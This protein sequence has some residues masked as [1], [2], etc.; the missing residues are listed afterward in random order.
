METNYGTFNIGVE[1]TQSFHN[2]RIAECLFGPAVA[3]NQS[4]SS[5]FFNNCNSSCNSDCDNS[6][7]VNVVGSQAPTPA[8]GTSD[9]IADAFLLPRDFSSNIRFSPQISNVNVPM[10]VYIGF[11][12]WIQGLYFR[13]YAPIT[14]TRWKLEANETIVNQGTAGY[15]AGEISPVVVPASSLY[16]SFLAYTSGGSITLPTSTPNVI[17]DPLAVQ[18]IFPGCDA[19]TKVGL[20]D[21]RA[22][23]GWDFL[24]DECYH[25]GINI[26]LAAP[27]GNTCSE[28]CLLFAPI[29]GNNKHWEFGGG[30]TGHYT[31]WESEDDEQRFGLYVDVD[32]THMFTKSDTQVFDLNDKPLSRYI[33]A[34]KLVKADPLLV[35]GTSS[36]NL[37]FANEFAPVAN[38]AMQNVDVSFAVQGD[39][40]AKF[41]YTCRGFDW[42]IGYNFW[43]RSCPR[44]E[45][46]CNCSP[47]FPENTWALRGN[48]QLYGFAAITSVVHPISATVSGATAFSIENAET[49]VTFNNTGVDNTASPVTYNGTT[50]EIAPAGADIS[51]SNPA[52]PITA[53]D[54]N[55]GAGTRGISNKIFTNFNYTWIDCED[56]IP[57]IGFGASAEFG[58][59]G[60]RGND[61]NRST[62]AC[63]TLCDADCGE[64]CPNCAVSQW[65]V[66]IKGGLSF[67]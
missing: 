9:L 63:P 14:W 40:V 28:S 42:E 29:V 25:L 61:N 18:R 54:L 24:R 64:N 37:Q 58:L 22:E 67:N 20:A 19:A 23:L 49:T 33:Y 48:A 41:V 27:T 16:Q 15:V 2:N 59:T 62:I 36:P 60:E 5:T 8:N 26:Q 30:L 17:V 52:M 56:W 45:L 6:V 35:V 12:E 21:L 50:L 53:N 47:V 7:T 1:Y 4:L 51:G 39:L 34:Q 31:F 11:D 55:I 46:S 57:Y 66:W 38:F 10:H 3:P 32:I 13:V 65:S 43:G 44:T